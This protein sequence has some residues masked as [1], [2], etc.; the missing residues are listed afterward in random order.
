MARKLVPLRLE[1][2]IAVGDA[3]GQLGE[4]RLDGRF[5]GKRHRLI[6][7]RHPEHVKAFSA[8]D[9]T[10]GLDRAANGNQLG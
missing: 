10:A 5:E 6:R 1:Q 7:M 2:E 3:V 9:A 4:H 8:P